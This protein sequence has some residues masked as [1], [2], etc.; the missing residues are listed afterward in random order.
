MNVLQAVLFADIQNKKKKIES[1]LTNPI[2]FKPACQKKTRILQ[3]E[4]R[5]PFD[6]TYCKLCWVAEARQA[7]PRAHSERTIFR[8]PTARQLCAIFSQIDLP[9]AEAAIDRNEPKK[10]EKIR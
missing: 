8:S 3:H 9:F 4:F 6:K 10:S 5:N 7:A 2:G 1:R